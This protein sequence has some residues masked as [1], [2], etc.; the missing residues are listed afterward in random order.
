MRLFLCDGSFNVVGFVCVVVV[1][2]PYENFV[3]GHVL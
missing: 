2:I 1:S 3:F